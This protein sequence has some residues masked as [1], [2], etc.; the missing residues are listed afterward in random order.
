MTERTPHANAKYNKYLSVRFFSSRARKNSKG[1]HMFMA[2]A[3]ELLSV[4]NESG[5]PN[6]RAS[7][8]V[9][10]PNKAPL[11]ARRP[12]LDAVTQIRYLS[13]SLEVTSKIIAR[14]IRR[15][16]LTLCHSA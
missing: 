4:M 2:K 12:K 16:L 5:G 1:R 11:M 6:T 3:N 15:T 13:R 9:R 7:P 14:V 8:D 10:N